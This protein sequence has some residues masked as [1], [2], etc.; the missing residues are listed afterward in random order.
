MEL[1]KHRQLAWAACGQWE[2]AS[3]NVCLSWW[4][5]LHAQFNAPRTLLNHGEPGMAATKILGLLNPEGNHLIRIPGY[6][7]GGCKPVAIHV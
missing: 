4:R 7:L 5:K 2:A 1:A 6:R 3:G